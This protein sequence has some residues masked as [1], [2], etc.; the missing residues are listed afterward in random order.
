MITE[1]GYPQNVEVVQIPM[2]TSKAW[3]IYLWNMFLRAGN[4]LVFIQDE[5]IGVQS[6]N[7]R[8]TPAAVVPAR[9]RV[10]GLAYIIESASPASGSAGSRQIKDASVSSVVDSAPIVT[11]TTFN[12]RG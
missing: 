1:A 12:F 8:S 7:D 5:H 6:A 4:A 9:A 3:M 2:T 11:G 10:R